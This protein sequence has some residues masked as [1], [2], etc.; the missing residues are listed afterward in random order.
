MGAPLYT[1]WVCGAA[2]WN[3]SGEELPQGYAGL[4]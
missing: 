1:P 3:G 2:V 4:F